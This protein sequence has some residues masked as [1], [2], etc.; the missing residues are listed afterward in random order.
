MWLQGKVNENE[1]PAKTV[2]V[3][4][5]VYDTALNQSA[6]INVTEPREWGVMLSQATKQMQNT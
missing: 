5:L 2:L 4:A 3:C 1:G 6:R